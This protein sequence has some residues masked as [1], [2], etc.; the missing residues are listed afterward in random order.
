MIEHNQTDSDEVDNIDDLKSLLQ[1][2]DIGSFSYVEISSLEA[3]QAA[4]E[5]WP[6]LAELDAWSASKS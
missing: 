6:L 5:K 3:W 1:H 4:L 2:L